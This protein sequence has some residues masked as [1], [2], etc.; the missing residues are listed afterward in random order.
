[1]LA[2]LGSVFSLCCDI[3]VWSASRVGGN[4]L[5]E[6]MSWSRH[7]GLSSA[8]WIHYP[9][10]EVQKPLMA[11]SS[12]WCTV[13]CGI[14]MCLDISISICRHN[15]MPNDRLKTNSGITK[16]WRGEIKNAVDVHPSCTSA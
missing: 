8:D 15:S 2:L 9:L 4:S 12:S 3:V 7:V 13:V 5:H 11:S 10:R 14:R 1:M 16:C 6:T